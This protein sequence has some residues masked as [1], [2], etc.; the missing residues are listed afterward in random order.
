MIGICFVKQIVLLV[1]TL[2]IFIECHYAQ[3]FPAGREK[4][5]NIQVFNVFYTTGKIGNTYSE[6]GM[7]RINI[8]RK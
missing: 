2:Q 5:L 7:F 1:F 3:C 4:K 8:P 6:Y